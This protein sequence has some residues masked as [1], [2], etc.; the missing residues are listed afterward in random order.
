MK[1][2]KDR[3]LLKAAQ[4]H[5]KQMA[6]AFP[7]KKTQ[8]RQICAPRGVHLGVSVFLVLAHQTGSMRDKRCL[9]TAA[10]GESDVYTSRRAK[11]FRIF[12]GEV[13]VCKLFPW[14]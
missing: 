10:R 9:L 4:T 12:A 2:S 14:R 1:P 8:W 13:S 3:F 5:E 7:A 6:A 11:A